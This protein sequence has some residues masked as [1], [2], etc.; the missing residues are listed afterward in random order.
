MQ[1]S[2]PEIRKWL[3]DQGYSSEEIEKIQGR[4]ADYDE[5]VVRGAMFD[6]I[7]TGELD[8]EALIQHAL[9]DEKP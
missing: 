9:N 4:L 7:N 8:L 6:A 5:T 1:P 3:E 2:D